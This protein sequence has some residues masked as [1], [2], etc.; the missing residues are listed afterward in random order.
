MQVTFK[1]EGQQIASAAFKEV[2]DKVNDRK[3]ISKEVVRPAAKILLKVMREY[4]PVLDTAPAFNVY[5]TRKK[6]AGMRAPNGM[7]QIYVSIKPQQLKKSIG[8]FQTK[9]S[10]SSG[11]LYVG[12]RYKKG[13]WKK[14][15]K[16]GWFMHMVQFGTEFVSP[17]PF[18]MPALRGTA[19]GVA[20]KM[21]QG[22]NKLLSRVC[23]K[24]NKVLEYK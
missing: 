21:E 17:Q 15:E 16:G 24:N 10:S 6:N 14:P 19:K 7:G 22:L 4:A 2:L 3:K 11:A 1:L 20:N 13:V 8:I 12:P 9:K 5:K 18:V 23:K